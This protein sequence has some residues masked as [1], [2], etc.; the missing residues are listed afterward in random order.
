MLGSCQA[1]VVDKKLRC[2]ICNLEWELGDLS[3]RCPRAEETPKMEGKKNDQ[4][5]SRV[6]LIDPEFIN[7]VGC[8]L[9]MGAEKYNEY[10]WINGMA[11]SR[12]TA[13]LLRHLGAWQ[14][15]E[16]LDPESGL[17]HLAHVAANVMFLM[18]YQ[19][20]DIGKD[21]R[22]FKNQKPWTNNLS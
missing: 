6:D 12:P 4:Y 20:N 8:I 18:N 16:D 10:N 19:R 21:D 14:R 11:W 5:K 2:D 1:K 17:S 15:G 13:A 3:A 22:G 7:E 9:H